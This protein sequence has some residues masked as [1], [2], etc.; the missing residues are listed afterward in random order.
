MSRKLRNLF[1]TLKVYLY[2]LTPRKKS[3]E[4][5]AEGKKKK[6]GDAPKEDKYIRYDGVTNDFSNPLY[7]KEWERSMD[8]RDEFWRD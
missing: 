7:D 6:S 5:A 8:N 4:P 1:Q 2:S 3:E